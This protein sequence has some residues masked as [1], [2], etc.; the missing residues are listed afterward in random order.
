MPSWTACG[1][2]TGSITSTCRPRLKGSVWRSGKLSGSIG[3]EKWP[4]KQTKGANVG[5][6]PFYRMSCDLG[7]SL[8]RDLTTD[9]AARIGCGMDVDIVLAG[10]E[11][12]GLRIG[13]R[14]ASFGRTGRRIGDRNHN[15]CIL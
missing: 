3:C 11:I 4:A 5:S 13:Q 15:A 14:G 6:A 10:Q 12:G 8:L 2:S 1:E 9:F 7:R